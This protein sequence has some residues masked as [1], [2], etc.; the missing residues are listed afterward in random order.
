MQYT[1]KAEIIFE[2]TAEFIE[3]VFDTED[4]PSKPDD[5][6]IIDYIVSNISVMP[7][8]IKPIEED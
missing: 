4:L 3:V 5:E 7:L 8:S 2:T 1:V 6:F